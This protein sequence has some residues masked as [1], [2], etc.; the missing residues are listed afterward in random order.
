M[1]NNSIDGLQRSINNLVASRDENDTVKIC[2][3]CCATNYGYNTV[4]GLQ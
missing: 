2:E 1:W 3:N 4:L